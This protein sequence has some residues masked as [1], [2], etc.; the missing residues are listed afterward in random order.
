LLAALGVAWL[1]LYFF[2]VH[3]RVCDAILLTLIHLL[4]PALAVVSVAWLTARRS[5]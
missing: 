1:G 5:R 2:D 3:V 4:V